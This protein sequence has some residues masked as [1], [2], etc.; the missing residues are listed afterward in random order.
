MPK[1]RQYDAA[2]KQQAVQLVTTLQKP[3]AEVAR[4][5]GVPATTLHQWLIRRRASSSDGS[6][7]WKRRMQS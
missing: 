2:F 6:E 1:N 5:L 3:V 4:D 7:I